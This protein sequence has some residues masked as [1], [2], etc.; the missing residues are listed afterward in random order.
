MREAP[1]RVLIEALA[2]RGATVKAYDPVAMDEARHIY[3]DEQARGVRRHRE[4]GR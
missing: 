2:D 1:S 4:G 3:G